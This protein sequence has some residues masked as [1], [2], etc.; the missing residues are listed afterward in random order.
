MIVLDIAIVITALPEMHTTLG[1]TD[2][3]LSWVQN[4]YL[5]TFGGFL[6]L[7]AR[8]GD[9]SPARMFVI[10]IA[11]FTAASLAVGL[12]HLPPGWL[13]QAVQVIGAAILAHRH[14][15]CSWQI[16]LKDA[17]APGQLP[18]MAP[19]PVWC[20]SRPC[21]RWYPHYL[22]SWRVAFFVNVPIG[23]VMMLA[24]PYYLAETER[25]PAQFDLTGAITN[26]RY[27][28]TCLWYR[29]FRYRRLD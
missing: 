15:H 27:D 7:G 8:S 24:A 2:T 4:A 12:H 17:N 22:D 28:G 18:T 9:I 20:Q 5:L 6:L 11:L 19:L 16:I 10:G 13:S 25:R 29:Q 14:L 21:Y 3:G 26:A 23:I 1:F